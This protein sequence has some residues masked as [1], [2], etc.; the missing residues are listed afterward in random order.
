MRLLSI[1]IFLKNYAQNT[2]IKLISLLSSAKQIL[3]LEIKR[4]ACIM[5]FKHNKK[6]IIQQKWTVP[7]NILSICVEEHVYVLFIFSYLLLLNYT[8]FYLF[9]FLQLFHYFSNTFL[10]LSFLFSF[11]KGDR[12]ENMAF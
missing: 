4:S 7:I 10:H 2:L 11:F 12:N 6:F 3:P 5:S 9:F 1:Y 8:V